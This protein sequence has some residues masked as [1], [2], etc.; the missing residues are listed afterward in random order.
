MNKKNTSLPG[1]DDPSIWAVLQ[2][3]WQYL[4]WFLLYRPENVEYL[5]NPS[6]QADEQP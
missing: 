4:F 5:N 2:N 3:A 1:I 6:P